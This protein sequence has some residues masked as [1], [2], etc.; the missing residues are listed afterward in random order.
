MV[1]TVLGMVAAAVVAAPVAVIVVARLRLVVADLGGAVPLGLRLAVAIGGGGRGGA[2][3]AG[4]LARVVGAVGGECR[5][6]AAGR[7][8][9]A[10]GDGDQGISELHGV[11]TS[12][13]G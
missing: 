2:G 1:R 6:A 5:S 11:F 3:R 7:Q 12:R 10:E 8:R 13:G 4:G 9:G